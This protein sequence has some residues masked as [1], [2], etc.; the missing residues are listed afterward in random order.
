MALK[1]YHVNW[2]AEKPDDWNGKLAI[3]LAHGAG[4]GMQSP[5]MSF[6][7]EGLAS[8]GALSVKFDFE[9]MEKGRK[10]PDRMPSLQEQYRNVIAGVVSEYDPKI[11]I[12]GG[13]SMGGRVASHLGEQPIVSGMVFLGYP[14]HPPKKTDQLRDAHL[15]TVDKPMLF[16]SGTRDTFAT[17]ELLERVTRTIGPHAR[18]HWIADGDHS[19]MVRRSG[20]VSWVEAL[21]AISD[22]MGGIQPRV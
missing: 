7:H 15:Y 2:F 12:I 10:V 5:F 1:I 13:K 20:K 21:K 18:L 6:F 11:L 17:P 9:Y 4:Q 22:W 19:L 14:L 3:I 8:L 16:I